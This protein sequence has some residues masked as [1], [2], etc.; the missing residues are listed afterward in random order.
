M[1]P[2][3]SGLSQH[4]RLRQR[5]IAISSLTPRAPEGW[6]GVW[7]RVRDFPP[8][9]VCPSASAGECYN[10]SWAGQAGPRS[11]TLSTASDQ[12]PP[13]LSVWHT[14]KC[15]VSLLWAADIPSG[16]CLTETTAVSTVWGR[17][18]GPLKAHSP[19]M[20]KGLMNIF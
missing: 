20:L 8:S 17:E 4:E 9:S 12:C 18:R 16:L 10:Q 15:P 7:A 2:K 5:H 13:G 19:R 3:C 1:I 14:P 11:L 6:E